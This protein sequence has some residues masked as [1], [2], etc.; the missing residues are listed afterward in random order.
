MDPT[1]SLAPVRAFTEPPD[2]DDAAELLAAAPIHAITFGFTSSAYVIGRDGER[3]HY[4]Q[5]PRRFS[6]QAE[7]VIFGGN[8]SRVVG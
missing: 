2:V 7:A 8:G 1:I 3:G 6:T 4:R 5:P